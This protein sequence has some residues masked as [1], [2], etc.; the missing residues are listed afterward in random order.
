MYKRQLCN[1]ELS[2]FI[3]G[4]IGSGWITDL[5]KLKGLEAF[6]EDAEFLR[7]FAEIK[8]MKKQELAAYVE[9]HDG[10]RL[11]LSLIHI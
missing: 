4:K 11:D 3:T 7:Q 9:K 8:Q 6:Q 2:G 1:Q 10:V 5:T